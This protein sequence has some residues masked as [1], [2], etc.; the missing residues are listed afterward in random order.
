M[1]AVKETPKPRL[2]GRVAAILNARELVIN[3]GSEAGVQA[4]QV[5]AILAATPL[6]IRDPASNQVLDRVDREK[7]RVKAYE[8]RPRIAI[9]RTYRVKRGSTSLFN[10]AHLMGGAYGPEV[11]E[12]LLT[13]DSAMPPP[14]SEQESYVKIN[15]RVVA[16]DDE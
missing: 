15:D 2:E 5:F 12:T 11:P 7:V 3:I 8:V 9:C 10:I 1:A 13:A 16:V 14:I 6:E 4:G